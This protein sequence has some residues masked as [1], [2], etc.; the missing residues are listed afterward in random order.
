[1]AVHIIS[2]AAQLNTATHLGGAGLD[3]WS[4]APDVSVQFGSV[5]DAP[6]EIYG[7]IG[8][9]LQGLRRIDTI[10]MPG[11]VVQIAIPGGVEALECFHTTRIEALGQRAY[12]NACQVIEQLETRGIEIRWLTP[13]RNHSG[14]AHA[15]VEA[16]KVITRM[17]ARTAPAQ[18]AT[19][20]RHA[21][22]AE[23]AAA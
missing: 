21:A 10:A 3:I 1:M 12:M 23:L 4:S 18:S 8:M 17:E 6:S 11:D 2:T 5:L 20:A 7:V 9:L 22:P 16:Q 14:I 15:R 13:V 19:P